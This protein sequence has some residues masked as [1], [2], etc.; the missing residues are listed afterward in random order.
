MANIVSILNANWA[1]Q[2]PQMAKRS[3]GTVN[4]VIERWKVPTNLQRFK[5]R[6]KLKT[7][8]FFGLSGH[9]DLGRVGRQIPVTPNTK[10]IFGSVELTAKRANQFL[11]GLRLHD[12][13]GPNNRWFFFFSDPARNSRHRSSSQG[14]Q[15]TILMS[16]DQTEAAVRFDSVHIATSQLSHDFSL[17]Y[18]DP[19]EL[20]ILL[21]YQEVTRTPPPYGNN[22]LDPTPKD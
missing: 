14:D 7:P 12:G 17:F 16:S 22:A 21:S 20:H 3:P 10:T 11:V 19:T 4:R 1:P 2:G 6:Y 13:F 18:M 5:L 8:L 15:L 9:L